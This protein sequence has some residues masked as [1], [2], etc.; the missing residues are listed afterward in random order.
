MQETMP[1]P[2]SLTLSEQ[3]IHGYMVTHARAKR[4]YMP[5]LCGST[6][7][8]THIAYRTTYDSQELSHATACL[9]FF[10]HICNLPPRVVFHALPP[11]SLKLGCFGSVDWV[12]RVMLSPP[13]P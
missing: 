13:Q 10:V 3:L 2:Q 5:P 1:R 6:P 12:Y 7:A 11:S 9:T 4:V 8:P